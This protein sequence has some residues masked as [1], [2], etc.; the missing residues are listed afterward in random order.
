MTLELIKETVERMTEQKIDRQCRDREVVYAR[1]MYFKLA[2]QYTN[3]PLNK[4][5]KIV[6]RHHASV[7]HGIKLFDDVIAKYETDYY[8]IYDRITLN[9]KK[10]QLGSLLNPALYYREKYARTLLEL[11]KERH[12]TMDLKEQLINNLI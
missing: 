12:K 5:G 8:Q 6:Y 10:R 4:I 11:R 2:K 1:A 7:I 9:L 3:Y